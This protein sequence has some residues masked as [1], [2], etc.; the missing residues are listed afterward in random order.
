[1]CKAFSCLVTRGNKVYWKAGVD[2]HEGILKLY[3]KDDCNLLDNK[4][5][6]L[7]TFARVEIVPPKEDYLNDNFLT[8]VYQIDEQLKPTFLKHKH[9]DLCR[10]ALSEW[11]KRVYTFNIEEARNPIHPFEIVPPKKITEKHLSL[12]K[13]VA[14]V[15]DSV[16][17]SVWDSVG[18][19]VRDSVWASVGASVWDSVWPSVGASVWDSV[20]A[21]AGSFFPI[22]EW[23]YV[24]YSNPLFKRG[25][26]PFQPF[27]DLWKMGLV[28]SFDGKT[29]RLNGGKDAKILWEG[30][31]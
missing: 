24:D 13:Q 28:P 21:Y 9:E 4:I 17:T 27:V 15:R 26:Y 5:P 22:E 16:R 29:W 2:S 20:W 14:S 6:P 1:M 19:S 30:K 11:G 10:E 3:Q 18:D 25:K 31:L 8:W 7:N 12:L 23:K